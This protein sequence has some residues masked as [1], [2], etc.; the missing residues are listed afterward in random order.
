MSWVAHL[1]LSN[2]FAWTPMFQK[3][4]RN[5]MY[6]YIS[7]CISDVFSDSHSLQSMGTLND[8]DN[9]ALL[10]QDPNVQMDRMIGNVTPTPANTITPPT[11]AVISPVPPSPKEGLAAGVNGKKPLT[12]PICYK[13][14]SRRSRAEACENKHQDKRPYVCRNTCGTSDWYVLCLSTPG[15]D[16]NPFQ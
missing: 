5:G 4:G 2:N 6:T 13:L 3:P 16:K 10:T 15:C 11:S 1:T 12:C 8:G 9:G 14:F 7:S